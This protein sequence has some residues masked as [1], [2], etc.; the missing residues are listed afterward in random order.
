MNTDEIKKVIIQAV[1]NVGIHIDLTNVILD[2]DLT[3]YLIS[4]HLVIEFYVNLEDILSVT[5]PCG[6]RGVE[7]LRSLNTY[8]TKP[9]AF[10]Q[11]A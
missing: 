3:E 5:L 4:E 6:M 10:L 7:N 2:V 9:T 11:N 1:N 8:T